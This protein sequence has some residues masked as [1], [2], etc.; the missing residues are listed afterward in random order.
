MPVQLAPLTSSD[1]I[2]LLAL[3]FT[4]VSAVASAGAGAWFAHRRATAKIEP[5][6]NRVRDQAADA[7]T[8]AAQDAVEVVQTALAV[9]RTQLEQS[10][11][12]LGDLQLTLD[13][14]EQLLA[15][16][17][18]DLAEAI[19][20]RDAEAQARAAAET[21]VDEL[22]AVVAELRERVDELERARA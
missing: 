1:L 20:D 13:N 2:S 16:A 14:L 12:E 4:I 11:A 22:S 8:R 15:E 17:R 7:I 10:Q 18:G 9:A 19:A 6:I 5:Q 3:V 21:R